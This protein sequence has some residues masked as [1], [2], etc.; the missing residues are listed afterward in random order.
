MTEQTLR[1]EPGQA[2]IAPRPNRPGLALA[3]ILSC[4]LMLILD[5]TV[6]NVALPR[7]RTDLGFTA[8]GLSWVMTSYSLVFG[9]LLLLGGR[10]GDLFGRRRMFVTGAAVFTVSSLVGGFAGSAELLIAAR[11]AQGVGAA[12][13][14][15][16]TLALI[17][18]TFTEAKARMR[19]LALFS[20]MAS[21]GFAIGLILGGLLTEWVSWRAVL[22]INVPVGL[23]IVTLAPR[24]V[25]DPPRRPARLDLPGAITGTLGVASLVYGFTRAASD[26]WGDTVTLASVT[27]GLLLLAGFLSLELRMRQPLVPLRLFADRNR[28]AAFAG[29]FL[30]P[31]AMMSMFFFLTQFL[32]EVRHFTALATGFAFLPMAVGI[33]TLS[34]LIPRLLP[35]YGPKPLAVTGTLMMVAGVGW[36]TRLTADTG[37]FGGL[38]GPM[39]LMGLGAGMAFAPLNIIIMASVPTEDAGAAGGVLQTMQQVGASLGLGILITVFG[40][41]TRTAAAGGTTG[42]ELL[43]S[44]MTSAFT[45]GT[46]IAGLG[47]L[48]A[49]T[50]RRQRD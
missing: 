44:G 37:Y 3:I 20:A 6:M 18:T 7:I 27:A 40:T 47:F 25:P 2:L 29:Y 48:V 50:F 17:T 13:A 46:A 5:A 42:T 49:L 34:R 10:A 39:V 16:S 26:G 28:A 22:F 36:L 12:L 43:V 15:P 38:F 11:V 1:R 19:A 45:V 23:A 31:M 21:S 33:F 32:Q 35:R 8:T 4:Q 9:G 14:G 24:F 30:G 41:A